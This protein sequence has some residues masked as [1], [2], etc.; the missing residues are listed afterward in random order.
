[1]RLTY[2]RKGEA[3][4]DWELDNWV[5]ALDMEEDYEVSTI[6]AIHRVMVAIAE[7]QLSADQI[8]VVHADKEYHMDQFLCM[9]LGACLNPD[10]RPQ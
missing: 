10:L 5:A 3:I 1:M 7:R 2:S 9:A 8:I 6:T 4:S